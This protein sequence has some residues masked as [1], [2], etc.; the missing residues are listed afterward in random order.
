MAV[1]IG[2]SGFI[3]DHWKGRFYPQGLAQNKWLE[4]YAKHFDTVELN[5]TFYRLP[6]EAAF[7]GWNERTPSKFVFAIK[8]SRFITHMKRMNDVA[9]PLKTFFERARPLSR[10]IGAVLWQ[11][12]PRF[13]RNDERLRSF[14]G[15]LGRHKFRHAFEFRHGS[16]FDKG[17]DRILKMR[18][19]AAVD[20][21]WASVAELSFP[22]PRPFLYIRRHGAGTRYG[23]NYSDRQLKADAHYIRECGRRKAVFVYFNN[24]AEGYAVKN[25]LRLK[26]LLG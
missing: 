4:Y 11:L 25:A 5:V 17:V 13:A 14:L 1:H 8:G 10:K 18:G 7:R 9:E 19:A 2:T 6:T 20:A 12:P 15:R 22:H 3:Y 26:E 24:D 16:W 23:G 21:D